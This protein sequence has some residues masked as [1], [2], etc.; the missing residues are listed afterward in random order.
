MSTRTRGLRPAPSTL[1]RERVREF[2]GAFRN[3]MHSMSKIRPE[4]MSHRNFLKRGRNRRP[5][6]Y[7]LLVLAALAAGAGIWAAI[8]LP[9]LEFGA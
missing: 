9:G 6:Q 2:I 5:L 7:L 1:K 4:Q 3:I 8:A